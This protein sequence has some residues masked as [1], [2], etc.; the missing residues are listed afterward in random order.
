MDGNAAIVPPACAKS[1]FP[2]KKYGEI[3]INVVNPAHVAA[4]IASNQSMAPFLSV[5]G[6]SRPISSEMLA[7]CPGLS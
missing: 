1:C 5:T 3:Q 4:S 2:Q 7:L 6:I